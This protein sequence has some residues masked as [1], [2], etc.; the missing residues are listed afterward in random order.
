[1]LPLGDKLNYLHLG[2]QSLPFRIPKPKDLRALL[3]QT[4]PLLTTSA[5][6]PGKPPANTIKEAIGYFG[7]KVD[8]YV[9]GGDL[10][11]RQPSTLIRIIDDEIQ[12]LR[13][14]AVKIDETGKIL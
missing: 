6:Q 11:G 9:D 13:Q 10:T 1:V 12:I 7:N 14:G 3:K 5:N 2:L 8:F 4:G